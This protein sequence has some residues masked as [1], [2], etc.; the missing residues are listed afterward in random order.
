MNNTKL[1]LMIFLGSM[2]FDL[3]SRSF[4]SESEDQEAKQVNPN[5]SQMS[6]SSDES[7]LH[8]TEYYQGSDSADNRE[9]AYISSQSRGVKITDSSKGEELEVEEDFGN[10]KVRKSGKSKQ[11]ADTS[12]MG[13]FL[14]LKKYIES[15]APEVF[16]TGG[17]YPPSPS[18]QMLA[19]LF[20]FAQM[21]FILF[22]FVGDSIFRALNKPVP[23]FYQRISENRWTWVI[24]AWFIGAQVQ[25]GLLS[26]GAFEIY[27]NDALE[28]S[29]IT[30]GRMP[31]MTDISRIFKKHSIEL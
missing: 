24:G 22:I 30:S 2:A 1:V 13:N 17:E 19:Q 18:K 27:V 10:G 8:N 11:R 4:A 29:K 26:S 14:Q 15:S 16:V 5:L 31:D 9:H 21:G 28:F 25:N 6:Q 23:A 7:M 12:E 3:I 20:S